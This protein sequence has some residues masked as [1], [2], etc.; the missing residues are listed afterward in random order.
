M[1]WVLDQ[2]MILLHPFMP[3][4]TEDLWA[5]TG[6][7]ASLL[8]LADWPDYPAGLVDEAAAAEM[9]W[10]IGLIDEI[11]SARAQVHVPVSLKL[12]MLALDMSEAARAAWT[13]NAALI[14][15]M[16]R[17]ESLT[18]AAAA[19]KGAITVAAEG[20]VFAIPLE[21]IIDIAAEKARLA[22]TLEK[23]EKEISGLAGRLNNPKFAVSAPE[24]VVEE[25]RANLAER[26]DEAAKLRAA[27]ARLAELG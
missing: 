11:R 8:A 18:D 5:T 25:A 22:K 10:V 1:A 17:V 6:K 12:N 3:F 13:R 15:R 14:Q 23:L 16:A 24:E 2:C 27:H 26:E 21:G 7:R 9:G 20:A 19:P 4:V